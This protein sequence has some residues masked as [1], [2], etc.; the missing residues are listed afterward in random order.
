MLTASHRRPYEPLQ[1]TTFFGSATLLRM[2]DGLGKDTIEW[3]CGAM[4][5]GWSGRVKK[6]RQRG[7]ADE[8]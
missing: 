1:H 5:I 4:E 6:E 3:D 7:Q 8:Y 2:L